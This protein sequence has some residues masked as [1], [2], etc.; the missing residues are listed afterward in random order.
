MALRGT[1]RLLLIRLHHPTVKAMFQ[2]LLI[3]HTRAVCI[4]AAGVPGEFDRHFGSHLS[5]ST[6]EG[7]QVT[8]C[9]VFRGRRFD[10]GKSACVGTRLSRSSDEKSVYEDYVE[11]RFVWHWQ[12]DSGQQFLLWPDS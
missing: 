7:G 2:A 4:P 1:H 10:S 11:G 3:E 5:A 12:H 8:E 9:L 6:G